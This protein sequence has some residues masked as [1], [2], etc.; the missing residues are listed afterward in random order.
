MPIITCITAS[1]IERQY[2]TQLGLS[3]IGSSRSRVGGLL[4][5]PIDRHTAGI[6]QGI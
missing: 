5:F 3:L 1:I 2:P 4:C 6:L